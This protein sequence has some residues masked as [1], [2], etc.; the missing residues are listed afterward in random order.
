M[1]TAEVLKKSR[2]EGTNDV[3]VTWL[4]E[5][6][7][8]ILAELNTH[9]VFSRNV[10]SSRA[11][12]LS[13]SITVL[14]DDPFVPLSWAKNRGG[15]SANED[16]R[17]FKGHFSR[18]VWKSAMYFNVASAWILGKVGLHK[19][20][21]N[22]LL[23]PFSY[24][25]AVVT[26]T[27]VENFFN[28]RISP[29]AQPEFAALATVMR[30]AMMVAPEQVLKP[31]EWH[32]P[33]ITEF[34]MTNEIYLQPFSDTKVGSMRNLMI[35]SSVAAQVSYRKAD[36]TFMKASAIFSKLT[37][38]GQEHASPF[39]HQL[40]APISYHPEEEDGW[41]HI[42]CQTGEMWSGNVRGFIQ[43]RQKLQRNNWSWDWLN[44]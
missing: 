37:E 26:T 21:A 33:F 38:K 9:R 27:E 44:K 36:R 14:L 29:A 17:P 5:L 12:P 28:L 24:T 34:D 13:A 32:L 15:M 40:M 22:R 30:D 7:R 31:G 18:A 4:I 23:E 35:S 2:V 39:E 1:I 43:L 20:Y 42:S 16:L 6:P 41:T 8:I 3:A 19:Q 25:K 10:Q 11:V